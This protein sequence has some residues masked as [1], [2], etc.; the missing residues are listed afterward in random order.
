MKVKRAGGACKRH[1][2]ASLKGTAH[3]NYQGKGLSKYLT[4]DLLSKHIEFASDPDQVTVTQELQLTRTLLA[5]RVE[6]LGRVD[7]IELWTRAKEVYDQTLEAQSK[8]DAQGF[9]NGLVLLGDLLE[10]GADLQEQIEGINDQTEQVRK[11]VDTERKIMA[12]KGEMMT[13]SAVLMRL[14]ALISL[15]VAELETVPNGN[16]I[17]SR[18]YE[19]YGEMA[20]L[21]DLPQITKS[22]G[23]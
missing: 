10:Q 17:I 7:S 1:G 12:D 15:F 11:L 9:A 20:G 2:G 16:N 8:K 3:P 19:L 23:R 22:R 5:S 14:D 18:V 4:G 21:S 13:R 6:L